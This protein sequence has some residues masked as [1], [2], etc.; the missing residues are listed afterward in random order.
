MEQL[1]IK[2]KK[3]AYSKPFTGVLYRVRLVLL[4]IIPTVVLSSC[5]KDDY[6]SG[7]EELCPD[8]VSTVPLDG[9][10]NIDITQQI[11]VTFNKKMCADLVKDGFFVLFGTDTIAGDIETDD[12]QTYVFIPA[13]NLQAKSGYNAIVTQD[14]ADCFGLTLS[15][16][17]YSWNFETRNEAPNVLATSPQDGAQGVLRNPEIKVEFDRAL[18]PATI[19]GKF[20]LTDSSGNDVDLLDWEYEDKTIRFIVGN[21]AALEQYEARLKVG[22]EDMLGYFIDDDFVW[23]FETGP[24][25]EMVPRSVKLNSLS[26]FAIFSNTLI[27]NSGNTNIIGDLGII[28]GTVSHITGDPLN[29]DG[30]VYADGADPIHIIN[31]I[32]VKGQN[33]LFAAYLFAEQTTNPAPQ[34]VSGNEFTPGIY[35]ID[36]FDINT[37][38]TL[39]AEDNPNA[40]WIF[41]VSNDLTVANNI[42]IELTNGAHAN[43][44]FWQVGNNVTIGEGVTFNGTI[45]ANNDIEANNGAIITGRLMVKEG[46]IHLHANTIQI[47]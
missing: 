46:A 25:F 37:N 32:L 44:I 42:D 45:M 38:I 33:D 15:E 4:L 16:G 39:D 7:P 30:N 47:P 27:D 29:V 43:N 17:A 18:N 31:P 14:V 11:S 26:D 20:E 19:D 9:D 23:E 10:T 40:F 6:D 21:L 5:M 8:V 35:Y 28:P 22:I 12:D 41:K 2:N 13:Q 36:D 34:P 24:D 1:A 3:F